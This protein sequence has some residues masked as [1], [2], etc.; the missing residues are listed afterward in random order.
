MV[1]A[2]ERVREYWV[3][4]SEST[5]DGLRGLYALAGWRARHACVYARLPRGLTLA[6]G[7]CTAF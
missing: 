3:C 5:L 2:R 6:Q 4:V 1:I 7:V